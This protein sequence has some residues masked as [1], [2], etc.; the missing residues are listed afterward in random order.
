MRR[1]KTLEANA[2]FLLSEWRWDMGGKKS[3]LKHARGLNARGK[4]CEPGIHPIVQGCEAAVK[5]KAGSR[6]S[7]WSKE[8]N[9][10]S[11]AWPRKGLSFWR[12][13]SNFAPP[14]H[15]SNSRS[16]PILE[17]THGTDGA[18]AFREWRSAMPCS[19]RQLGADQLGSHL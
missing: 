12:G 18:A 14:P 7:R 9:R 6:K 10:V 5:E 2:D 11:R 19:I 3:P 8:A 4:R 13:V 1:S 15:R 16:S 17:T